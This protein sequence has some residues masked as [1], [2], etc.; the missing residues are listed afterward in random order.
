[1]RL[2]LYGR[3]SVAVWQA[4]GKDFGLDVAESLGTGM[5]GGVPSTYNLHN[6]DEPVTT[7]N[8]TREH[9]VL[10]LWTTSPPA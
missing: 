1:M 9:H 10:P 4:L 8:S 7:P 6:D 5:V 2:A 3:S